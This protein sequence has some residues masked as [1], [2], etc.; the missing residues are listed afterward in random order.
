MFQV[1]KDKIRAKIL[2]LKIEDLYNTIGKDDILEKR[3]IG[4]WV[5]EKEITDQEMKQIIAEAEIFIKSKLWK[6]LRTDIRYQANMKMFDESRDITDLT[7]GKS[8]LWILDCIQS[9]LKELS[10]IK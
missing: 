1:F 2:T 5:G 10:Q 8:W 4:W 7:M 9:R 6:V 3:G